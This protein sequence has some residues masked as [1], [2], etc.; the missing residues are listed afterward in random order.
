MPATV[1]VAAY[2]VAISMLV[3][4]GLCALALIRMID[5]FDPPEVRNVPE[6][7]KDVAAA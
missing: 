2:V 5:H 7:N 3:T 1:P 6:N 4:C